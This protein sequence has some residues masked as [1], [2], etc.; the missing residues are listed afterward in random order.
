[1]FIKSCINSIA[2]CNK[3]RRAKGQGNSESICCSWSGHWSASTGNIDI[4]EARIQPQMTWATYICLHCIAF[5]ALARRSRCCTLQHQTLLDFKYQEY[6][7]THFWTWCCWVFFLMSIN[8][9]FRCRRLSSRL[10][11]CFKWW[12]H[13]L[14]A[15]GNLS[16]SAYQIMSTKMQVA[17]KT[18]PR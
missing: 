14:V 12:W 7:A 16:Q 8:D 6:L 9:C 3:T 13:V 10:L 18:P 11:Y 2:D 1:M 15:F 5:E 4:W 17:S